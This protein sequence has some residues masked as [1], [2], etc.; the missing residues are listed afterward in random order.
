MSN[1]R[2][3]EASFVLAHCNH[4]ALVV[5]SQPNMPTPNG[6]TWLEVTDAVLAEVPSKMLFP[7]VGTQLQRDLKSLAISR[8]DRWVF[9]RSV[10]PAIKKLMIEAKSRYLAIRN[11][12]FA[13]ELYRSLLRLFQRDP[14]FQR[15]L[16]NHEKPT[17]AAFAVTRRVLGQIYFNWEI[18]PFEMDDQAG[19]ALRLVHEMHEIVY[20]RLSRYP[21]DRE[22]MPSHR[23]IRYDFYLKKMGQFLGINRDFDKLFCLFADA[24]RLFPRD[25]SSLYGLRLDEF[26]SRMTRIGET[27]TKRLEED[28]AVLRRSS[29]AEDNS[30]KEQ[31]QTI[32]PQSKRTQDPF[33][34]SLKG[35]SLDLPFFA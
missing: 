13:K 19:F 9:D 11:G 27:I 26:W 1:A 33:S 12:V 2:F 32:E 35:E 16:S 6:R 15:V 34:V 3:F 31:T 28:V 17:S 23:F 30:Q 20:E 5:P 22:M 25:G 8:H 29:L 24:C 18:Q 7:L 4:R 10:E 14:R 21:I